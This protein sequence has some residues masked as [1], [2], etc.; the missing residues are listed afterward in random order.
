M[1]IETLS[2]VPL[3]AAR[4]SRQAA[5]KRKAASWIAVG[6]VHLLILSLLLTSQHFELLLRPHG[7]EHEAILDLSGS[8]DEPAPQ[9]KMVVPQA[10]VGIPP[11]VTFTPQLPPPPTAIQPPLAQEG[12]QQKGDLLGALGRD[13]ACSPGHYENLTESQR[14]RCGRVPWL[15]AMTPDGTI[16]LNR[17][18]TIS[19]FAPPPRPYEMSGQDAQRLQVERATTDCPINLNVPCVNNIPGLHR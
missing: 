6:I 12:G 15:G 9:V 10:P 3:F 16:V 17:P 18:A 4:P 11:E 13:I 14:S 8:H 19:P 1:S 5:P 2:D 7:G